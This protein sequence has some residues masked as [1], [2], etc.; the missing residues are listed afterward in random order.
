MR[1]SAQARFNVGGLLLNQ[2]FKI[3]RL[4]HFGFNLIKMEE[5]VRFYTELL[6]FRI[7]DNNDPS[8]RASSPE[9]IAGL[10]DP[11]VTNGEWPEALEPMSDSYQGE[12]FLGPWG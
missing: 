3:R 2:P 8:R 9:Q 7:S 10:G 5:G 1:T 6:G 12:P 4:G 11:K